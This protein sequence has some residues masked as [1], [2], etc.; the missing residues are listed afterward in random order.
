MSEVTNARPLTAPHHDPDLG[1]RRTILAMVGVIVL[2]LVVALVWATLAELDVAVSTQG[3]V[4]A[5][6][7][8]QEV[9]SLEGGIVQQMLVAPGQ[10]VKKGQVLARL[11]SAQYSADLGESRQQRLAALI[12]RARVEALLSGQPPRF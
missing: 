12:G 7:R 3:S 8:L 6:S 11:D 9:Q 5:P 10:A 1:P 2:F 4:V